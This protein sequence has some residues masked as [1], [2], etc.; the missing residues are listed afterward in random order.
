MD[1]AYPVFA[2]VVFA[3][4]I[5]AVRRRS[6][7]KTADI[8]SWS[9]AN[10]FVAVEDPEPLGSGRRGFGWAAVTP[11]DV[12]RRGG[13]TAATVIH[14]A[15]RNDTDEIQAAEVVLR[16]G[17]ATRLLL[18][19][20][21]GGSSK[22]LGPVAALAGLDHVHSVDARLERRWHVYA[23]DGTRAHLAL[24]ADR[25]LV[26][27]LCSVEAPT[28]LRAAKDD[29]PWAIRLPETL[30]TWKNARIDVEIGPHH[31]LVGVNGRCSVR[32][33]AVVELA[34]TLA[35]AIDAR[36]PRR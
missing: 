13:T 12:A 5:V 33:A 30:R 9:A 11:R 31:L 8:S 4:A 25:A 24:A 7:T 2:V 15:H 29:G 10:G 36:S 23:E 21:P 14:R 27:V 6:V 16:H 17:P 28:W 18:G 20:G 22:L 35:A 34:E 32:R 26:D 1:F 19:T 3:A